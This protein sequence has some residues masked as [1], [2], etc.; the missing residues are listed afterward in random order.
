M[1]TLKVVTQKGLNIMQ[2]RFIPAFLL[3]FVN[4]L[5]FSLLIPVLPFV[6]E[7]YGSSETVYGLLLS[8][9]SLCQFLA[10]PWLGR[11]SDSY[12]RKPILMV[13]QAGTLLSWVFF[14]LAWFIPD[15]SLG[16]ISLPLVVILSLIHI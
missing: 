1:I 7:Q 5:G 9:Y 8:L 13:S 10:A 4:V 6:V 2:P 16:L 12:G 3:T 15:I 14:S 11:L